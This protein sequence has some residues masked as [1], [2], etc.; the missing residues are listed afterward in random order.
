MKIYSLVRIS[1]AMGA[2]VAAGAPPAPAQVS[3]RVVTYMN[4][5]GPAGLTEGSPGVFYTFAQGTYP[6]ALSITSQGAKTLLAAFA[7][8]YLL[9]SASVVAENGR[10]YSTIEYLSD[11]AEVVSAGPTPGRGKTFL[12]QNLDPY[13]VQNLPDGT[14]L[15]VSVWSGW[16]LNKISINDDVT[17]LYQFPSGETPP[18]FAVYGSD[19]N[20][21]GISVLPSGGGYFYRIT[22]AGTRTNLYTFA[23]N[24]FYTDSGALLQAGDGNFYGTTPKGGA[25]GTGTIYKVTPSGQYTLLYAFPPSTTSFAPETLIEASDGNLY[26]AAIGG[27]SQLFRITKSGAFTLLKTMNLYTEGE[28]YCALT[29]GSDGI[30]YGSA[31]LGGLYGGGDIFALDAGLPKPAPRAQHFYPQSGPVGARV[32][33]WGQNLL[34]ASVQFNGVAATAVTNAGP[35]YVW[36]VVPS[37]ATTGPL[38]ITTPGGAVTTQAPF[39]VE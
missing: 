12:P 21:Y 6:V 36:A 37:G 3:F 1:V 22:P 24:V 26:G 39:T 15:A 18:P 33:I 34:S 11:P 38:T 27:D 9:Q 32:R 35:N 29:Q 20:Y 16:S 5:P 7:K 28:C 23:G 8:L 19:G 25:N 17:T 2:C 10:L 30:I 31:T 4:S 14:L 13:F